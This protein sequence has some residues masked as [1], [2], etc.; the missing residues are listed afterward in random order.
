MD[1]YLECIIC[2]EKIYYKNDHKCRMNC[3]MN[4]FIRVEKK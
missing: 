2:N 1:K 4:C 3:F